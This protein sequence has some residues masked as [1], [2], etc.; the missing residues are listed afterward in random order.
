MIEVL[1]G[2]AVAYRATTYEDVEQAMKRLPDE[3]S[4]DSDTPTEVATQ[5]T[6][7]FYE[8]HYRKWVDEP[9]PALGG[10]TPR[11]AARLDSPRPKL[12]ALLKSMENMAVRQRR[13]GQL[14]YDFGWMWGGA[15]AGAA[16]VRSIRWRS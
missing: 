10:R 3:A 16:G 4:R 11:E 2:S 8:E 15:G 7:H 12:I 6:A 5:L 9:L 13:A 14:A 1:A